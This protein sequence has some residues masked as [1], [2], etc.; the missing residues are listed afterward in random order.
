MKGSPVQ[1]TVSIYLPICSLTSF[2]FVFNMGV[3]NKMQ[4]Y[5]IVADTGLRVSISAQCDK[6]MGRTGAQGRSI[7]IGLGSSKKVSWK[8]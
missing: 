3:L 5:G 7:Y 4:P 6:V 2:C 1:T 8:R